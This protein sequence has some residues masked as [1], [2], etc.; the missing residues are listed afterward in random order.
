[1][2]KSLLKERLLVFL[3]VV[4]L[5]LRPGDP[6]MPLEG[7]VHQVP[8]VDDDRDRLAVL[9]RLARDGLVLLGHAVDGVED[10]E[11]HVG[12]LHRVERSKPREVLD[13]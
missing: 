11:H 7:L 6:A 5:A 9:D 10:Q 13:R 2:K 4:A 1:M 12:P 8:L 3:T